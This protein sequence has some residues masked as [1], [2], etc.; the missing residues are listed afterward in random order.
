MLKR[1]IRWRSSFLIKGITLS[2]V[3]ATTGC[4]S[5]YVLGNRTVDAT[6]DPGWWGQLRKGEILRLRED[7]LLNG[8]QV[9]LVA[10]KITSNYDS[11]AIFER[12]VTVDMFKANPKAFWPELH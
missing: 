11:Q 8:I 2:L 1:N 5:P 9:D 3:A 6:N 10:D 7:A 4:F 12:S